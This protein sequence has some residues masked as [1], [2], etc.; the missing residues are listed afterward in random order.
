MA[1]A[2]GRP[3][4]YKKEYC[5]QIVAYFSAP[6]QIVAYERTYFADGTL[7]NERPIVMPAQFPSLYGFAAKIEVNIDSIYEWRDK[8]SEFSEAIARAQ[9]LQHNIWLVNGMSG[10]YNS[11]FAQF[12]GKN[13]LGYKDKVE[14]DINGS[15]SLTDA[16]RELLS[17][18][19][20]RQSEDA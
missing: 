2:G 14:A 18:I 9:E 7:K 16:D 3:T 15:I 13:C 20:K 10:Q 11:Q 6:P 19:A 4:K 17:K 12:F 1:H 8:H 5:E